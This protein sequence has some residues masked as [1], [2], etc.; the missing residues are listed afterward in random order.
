MD[1]FTLAVGFVV[2]TF[3]GASGQYLAAKYT[4]KRRSKE[5]SSAQR[6]RWSDI[7]KR[8]PAIIEEMKED[9][10]NPEL[11]S[12]RE[13]FVK[14]SRTTVNRDEPC[15][16]YYTDVHN[17]IGAAVRYLEEQGYIEDV[18]PGNCPMYRMRE[19]FVDQLRNS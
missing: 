4:D 14:S 10:K 7:E 13:F 17:D 6:D 9:A 2:G 1:L 12:V 18:T 5:A 19:H 3:T 16:A 8:F 15:F 11:Q